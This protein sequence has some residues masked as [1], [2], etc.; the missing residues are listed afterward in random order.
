MSRIPPKWEILVLMISYTFLLHSRSP[1]VLNLEGSDFPGKQPWAYMPSLREDLKAQITVCSL[2]CF[3]ID[4]L[5]LP[6]T[7]RRCRN[8]CSHQMARLSNHALSPHSSTVRPAPE[9]PVGIPYFSHCLRLQDDLVWCHFCPC[10]YF[11]R[12]IFCSSWMRGRAHQF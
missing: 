6:R 4:N 12:L 2:Q 5:W 3:L 11:K 1:A 9:S 8:E 7:R 10:F